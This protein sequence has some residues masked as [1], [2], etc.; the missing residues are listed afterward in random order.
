[1]NSESGGAQERVYKSFADIKMGEQ[2]NK[3]GVGQMKFTSKY[4]SCIVVNYELSYKSNKAIKSGYTIDGYTSAKFKTKEEA[5]RVYLELKDQRER[6]LAETLI[7]ADYTYTMD[8]CN[9]FREVNKAGELVYEG[10]R[11][12]F[13]KF[14][15]VVDSLGKTILKQ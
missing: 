3:Q 13:E 7:N 10:S 14:L 12:G 1:M 2:A 4:P 11:P 5:Y 9:L 6:E 8:N 15:D